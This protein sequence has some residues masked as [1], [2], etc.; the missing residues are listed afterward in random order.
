MADY[1]SAYTGQQIDEGIATAN[2]AV[3]ATRTVNGKPLNA[4]VTLTAADV[5]AD[6]SGAASGVQANLSNHINDKSNP[7]GVTA[8]QVG[9]GNVDNT[10]DA[11]KPISTATQTALNGKANT[12]H[13]HAAGDITSGT[14]DTARLPVIPISKGGTGA[15]TVEAALSALGALT[16]KKIHTKNINFTNSTTGKHELDD[17][18]GLNLGQ[19][20]MVFV[21]LTDFMF[22]FS[23]QETT[24]YENIGIGYMSGSSFY[25]A[26]VI[27]KTHTDSTTGAS[28]LVSFIPVNGW[29][30]YG[31]TGLQRALLLNT[32]DTVSCPLELLKVY[33]DI[34]KKTTKV[35]GTVTVYALSF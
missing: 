1:N 14:L 25:G 6:A 31:T 29:N 30:D 4:D 33:A 8:A 23:S 15:A 17:L 3:P 11:D 22:T 5:G 35:T 26:R 27:T 19:Y 7:H 34:D 18:S 20:R 9:L 10:A 32:S 2:A 16:I 24:S 13:T 12:S 28:A 21:E